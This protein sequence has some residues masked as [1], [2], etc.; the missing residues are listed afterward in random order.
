MGVSAEV[1][2]NIR[3][4]DKGGIRVIIK[5]VENVNSLAGCIVSGVSFRAKREC[6][7]YS[8]TFGEFKGQYIPESSAIILSNIVLNED[9]KMPR[10]A[11][12]A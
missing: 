5:T 9:G 6:G 1:G 8:I 2:K 10:G 12:Y 4:S 11:K 3:K 7:G